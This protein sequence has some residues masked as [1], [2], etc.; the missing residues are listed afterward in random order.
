MRK[1]DFSNVKEAGMFSRPED[2]A[3]ICKITGVKN[4][5]VESYL[6]IEY[7]IDEG[8]FKGYYTNMRERG[9]EWAG[10]YRKYYTEK[11]APFWNR[12][13]HRVSSCNG[14]YVFDGNKINSDEQTLIGKRIG[15]VFQKELYSGNDGSDKTR[16]NVY[17]E[18]STDDIDKQKKPPV[19]D[20]RRNYVPASE[21]KPIEVEVGI[22]EELPFA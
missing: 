16:F 2:G 8:E 17:S 6:E 9:F 7:D 5:D 15:L 21:F 11:A 4:N 20:S 18:F 1:V 19:K 14:N 22:D 13:C 3:F 10:T 12:F